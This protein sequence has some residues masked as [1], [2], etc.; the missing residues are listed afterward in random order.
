MNSL[1]DNINMRILR[2]LQ[3]NGRLPNN[4]LAQ[5]VGLSSS[6]CLRRVNI[7]EESGVID[8]YAAILNPLKIGCQMIVYVLG[9]FDDEDLRKRERFVFEMK[10]LPNIIEC[11]LMAGDYDFILKV[12]VADLEQFNTFKER[13]LN[14]D[15]GIRNTKS[16]I[17]LKTIKNT[18]EMPL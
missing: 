17:I 5:E 3:K 8:R 18:T 15:I 1:L 13:Y 16:E 12:Q 2:A 9:T 10:L 6:A 14:K 4:E 7:L 11:H